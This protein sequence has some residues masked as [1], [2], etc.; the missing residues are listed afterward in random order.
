MQT[1]FQGDTTMTTVQ[2]QELN[3]R[4]H[5]IAMHLTGGTQKLDDGTIWH[6]AEL[7]ALTLAVEKLIA[8]Q[9]SSK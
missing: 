3:T 5:H 8:N 9:Q 2:I 7:L 6:P 1:F 4:A